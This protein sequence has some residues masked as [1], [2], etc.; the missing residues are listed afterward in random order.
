[1]IKFRTFTLSY[2]VK[3]ESKRNFINLKSNENLI[4][5]LLDDDFLD[6]GG[7]LTS[8][9]IYK[10][11]IYDEI[12]SKIISYIESENVLLTSG[13]H[14]AIR[15]ILS[16]LSNDNKVLLAAPNYSGYELHFALYKIPYLIHMRGPEDPHDLDELLSIAKHNL[17]N[18]IVITNPDP[19]SG[20]FFDNDTLALFLQC[21]E[22]EG[23]S[24]IVDEVYTGMGREPHTVLTKSH[25]N[26]ILINSFAKSFG[27]PGLRVGWIIASEKY[28]LELRNLFPET[29]LSGPSIKIILHL[30]D[31][32]LTILRY[33]D[34]LRLCRSNMLS[35]LKGV[36]DIIPYEKSV[37]NFILFKSLK[38]VAADKLWETLKE[39]GFYIA[40]LNSFKGY[41]NYFRISVCS[42]HECNGLLNELSRI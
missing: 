38:D 4:Y 41:E 32:P 22:T 9:D 1:M 35:A 40:N 15:V 5:H 29:N 3:K 8:E 30:L 25:D 27:L 6:L 14:D 10:Y 19:Y 42:R 24:V 36:S 16:S 12:Y 17:C 18:L 39:N 37:T 20:D 13:G 23:I 7:V 28:L 33:R 2:I 34:N 31:K 21:C 26:L 11:P